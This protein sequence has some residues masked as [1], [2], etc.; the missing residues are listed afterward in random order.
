MFPWI[1]FLF[2]EGKK[3]SDIE[4]LAIKEFDSKLVK[5]DGD[6]T[7]TGDIASLTASSGKDMYLASAKCVV[8][9]EGVNASVSFTIVLKVNGTVE[10]T[11]RGFLGLDSATTDGTGDYQYEFNLKGAKVAATEII[12]IE[13]T[14]LGANIGVA[15]ELMC[16]EETTGESPQV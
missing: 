13:A 1:P 6:I 15:G 7:A 5:A 14:V 4:Y 9:S 8:Y 16:I 2:G 3:L 12:K 10:E 11:F